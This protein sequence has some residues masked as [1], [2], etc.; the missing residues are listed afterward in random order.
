LLK[1]TT[2][3]TLKAT[4]PAGVAGPADIV[5]KNDK[6]K[7]WSLPFKNFTYV[8]EM[9]LIPAG[10]FQIGD[11]FN[12]DDVNERPVHT[13]Y[14]D[15]FYIDKY[16]VTNAQY[17]KFIQATGHKEPEGVGYINGTWED[18]FKPWSDPDFNGDTQPV[19]CIIWE[20]AKDYANWAGKGLPT[21][22]MWEKA[23]R[24]RLVGKRYPWGN[25]ITHDDAKYADTGGKDIWE[26]TSPVGSF[27]PN[28]YGLYDMTG[29]V[30]EWCSDWYDENYYSG[31]PKSNPIGPS[32][33][34]WRVARGGLWDYGGDFAFYLRVAYRFNKD[35]TEAI[36]FM[37]FRCV[38][39]IPK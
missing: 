30:Y 14:L 26:H 10:E 3:T 20:D 21:E 35:P 27:A 13:V 15:A 28:G 37:G 25:T 6:A 39:D 32:S 18:G 23:A 7:V 8:A 12:K 29:N 38:Q 36:S 34:Q 9:V 24:G 1:C 11:S 17:K 5:V 33:G 22:A 31:S 19:V 16:E 2:N 4:V